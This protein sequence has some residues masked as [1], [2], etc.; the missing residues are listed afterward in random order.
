MVEP[1][2]YQLAHQKTTVALF[3]TSSTIIAFFNLNGMISFVAMN[4]RLRLTS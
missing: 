2:P 1:L 3:E 4:L